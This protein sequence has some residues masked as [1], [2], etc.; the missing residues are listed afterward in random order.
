[1]WTMLRRCPHLCYVACRLLQQ[2]A[3]VGS[4]NYMTNRLQWILNAAAGTW[5]FDQNLSSLLYND[6]HWLNI[7]ERINYKLNITAS[8][9]TGESSEVPG[10]LLH[11]SFG[12]RWPSTTMLGQ[13]N[14][15]LCRVTD[16]THSSTRPFQSPVLLRGTLYQI[17]SMIQ[18]W[19]LTVL[20]NYLKW[21]YLRV[22][23]HTNFSMNVSWFCT[24][25]HVKFMIESD[26]KQLTWLHSNERMP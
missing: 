6:L 15:L 23:K 12:S 21:N 18:H 19:V 26:I 11:T 22:I 4:P 20:G 7:P 10:R 24:I 14:T 1:M 9:L 16:W 3:L 5:K 13:S 2:P 25:L 17:V 8:L